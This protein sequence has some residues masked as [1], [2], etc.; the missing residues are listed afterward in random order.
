MTLLAYCP[1]DFLGQFSGLDSLG[2][3]TCHQL[4]LLVLLGQNSS[5]HCD[6][7]GFLVWR[8]PVGECSEV[9]EEGFH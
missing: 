8:A 4:V 3:A 6:M 2:V 5:L 7:N 1:L 9:S